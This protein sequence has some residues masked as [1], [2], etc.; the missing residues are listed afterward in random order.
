MCSSD[1]DISGAHDM[2]R[3]GTIHNNEQELMENLRKFERNDRIVE[4]AYNYVM[5]NHTVHDA[6]NDIEDVLLET[7][8]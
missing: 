7:L 5:C 4:D 8:R 1:L 3:W 2:K 6:C